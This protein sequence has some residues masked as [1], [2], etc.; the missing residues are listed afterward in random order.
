VAWALV[1][2]T[3]AVLI[4]G[5]LGGVL[6][7]SLALDLVALW[8][9]ALPAVVAVPLAFALGRRSVRA[10]A[11]PGLLLFSWLVLAFAFHLAAVPW[12]PSAEAD[13]I[14]P[15]ATGPIDLHAD[16]GNGVLGVEPLASGGAAYEVTPRRTGG[17]TGAPEAFEQQQPETG[18]A[19]IL[20]ESTTSPWYRFGGWD[21][22]LANGPA[23]TLTLAAGRMDVDLTGLMVS[24]L[25]AEAMSGTVRLGT[26]RAAVTITGDIRVVVPPG[27]PVEVIGE[28]V[29]PEEWEDVAGGSRSPV[30]GEGWRIE[31]TPGSTVEVLTR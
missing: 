28:A 13:L 7:R 25:V 9:F 1:V 18:L 31:V 17:S 26:S 20:A 11:V 14:G 6:S 21:L 29:V 2:L 19:V 5:V 24:R 10:H 16:V 23:W 30:A 4:A 8:P 15:S 3:V 12:L 22:G 27:I